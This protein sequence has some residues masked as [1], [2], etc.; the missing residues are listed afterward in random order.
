[1]PKQI[2]HYVG[3]PTLMDGYALLTPIDHPSELVSNTRQVRTS[4]VV[5]VDPQSGVIETMNTIY[6]PAQEVQ[7]WAET[8]V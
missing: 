6:R 4:S 2:V 7:L 5:N 8:D 1:M 3:T